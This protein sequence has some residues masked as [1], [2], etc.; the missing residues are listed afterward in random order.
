MEKIKGLSIGLSGFV[1]FGGKEY[2]RGAYL[3]GVGAITDI[4]GMLCCFLKVKL[5]SVYCDI[6]FNKNLTT[7]HVFRK[8]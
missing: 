7:I 1:S 8:F 6:I 3:R 2:L 4:Y 5:E